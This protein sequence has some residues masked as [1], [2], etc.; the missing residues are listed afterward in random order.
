MIIECRNDRVNEIYVSGLT[1]RPQYQDK[2]NAI[3]RLLSL[4]ADKYD[5][6]YIHNSNIKQ[7]QLWNDGLHLRY[8]DICRLA[9]TFTEQVNRV[10]IYNNT[11][12]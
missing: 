3:S 5:C 2:V 6:H 8:N 4:N 12:V 10:F 7:Y 9:Q 1:C 11:W